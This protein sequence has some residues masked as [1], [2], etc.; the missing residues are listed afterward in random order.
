[1]FINAPKLKAL[2]GYKNINA[3]RQSGFNRGFNVDNKYL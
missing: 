1:L 3:A 2:T